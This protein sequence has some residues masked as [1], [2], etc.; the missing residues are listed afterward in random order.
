MTPK[1][2]LIVLILILFLKTIFALS[3]SPAELYFEGKVNENICQG[4]SIS[5]E[6]V[7][8]NITDKWVKEGIAERNINLYE[9][10][11]EKFGIKMSYVK[12]AKVFDD[13]FLEICLSGKESGKYF[14]VLLLQVKEKSLGIG[15]WMNVNLIGKELESKFTISGNAISEEQV[16]K[17][18]LV[19]VFVMILIILIL[20][21]IYLLLILRQK[22]KH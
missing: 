3:V 4:L 19:I 2:I 8:V 5:G 7:R 13:I 9:M 17:N 1:K 11:S 12:E 10:D 14:G 22:K 20:I 21:L 16:E 15:I 18:N 6:N